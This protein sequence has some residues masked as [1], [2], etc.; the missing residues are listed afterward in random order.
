[1]SVVDIAGNLTNKAFR[2]DLP[3]VL[4][5]AEAAGVSGIVVAGVSTSTSRRGWEMA[6][7]WRR[8]HANSPLKLVATAGF[9]PHH[10]SDASKEALIEIT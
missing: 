4:S 7:D 1:M 6:A 10:A 2:E 9:H 8:K 5:R 3:D